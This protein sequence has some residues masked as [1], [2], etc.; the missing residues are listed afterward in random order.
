MNVYLAYS[1]N[2]YNDEFKVD[3]FDGHNLID[4]AIFRTR[5][6]CIKWVKERY[7]NIA[8]LDDQFEKQY[9]SPEGRAWRKKN[10]GK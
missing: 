6:H 5:M 2:A 4:A 7:G 8:D 10:P 9:N 1:I 3:V